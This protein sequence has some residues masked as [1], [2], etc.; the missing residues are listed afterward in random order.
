MTAGEYKA[1]KREQRERRNV[2]KHK[3][4]EP[5]AGKTSETIDADSEQHTGPHH[6]A[7]L[8]FKVNAAY[9]DCSMG[10]DD[11]VATGYGHAATRHD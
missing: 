6:V 1:R 4:E 8:T 9:Y 3:Q 7:G 11:R 5:A 2:K 10:T